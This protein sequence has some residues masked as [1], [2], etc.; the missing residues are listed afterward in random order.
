MFTLNYDMFPLTKWNEVV[1]T[2]KEGKN[3][4]LVVAARKVFKDQNIIDIVVN[5]QGFGLIKKE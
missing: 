5:D 3:C 1:A 2:A 4:S